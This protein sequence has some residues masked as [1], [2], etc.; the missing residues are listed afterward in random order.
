MRGRIIVRFDI[1]T[2][3]IV[4]AISE[5]LVEPEKIR[6]LLFVIWGVLVRNLDVGHI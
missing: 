2:R 5:P 3:K 6:Y 4:F 1:I